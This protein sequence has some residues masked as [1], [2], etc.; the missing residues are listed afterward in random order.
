MQASRQA[1]LWNLLMQKRDSDGLFEHYCNSWKRPDL[2]CTPHLLDSPFLAIIIFAQIDS[3][4]FNVWSL[5]DC[6]NLHVWSHWHQRLTTRN[7]L[8]RWKC[9]TFDSKL[10]ESF[11]DLIAYNL[12]LK[13]RARF[14]S[15]VPL[16]W[17]RRW[18]RN[19]VL[20]FWMTTKLQ[21]SLQTLF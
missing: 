14:H 21:V 7:P 2:C 20:S 19:F 10:L 15:S 18:K 13:T 5:S 3:N 8:Q 1:P 17:M 4:W 16:K 9:P 6:R 12:R 11:V